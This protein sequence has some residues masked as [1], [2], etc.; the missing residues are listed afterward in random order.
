MPTI[1]GLPDGPALLTGLERL[2]ADQTPGG[3]TV[4]LSSASLATLGQLYSALNLTV[5][6]ERFDAAATFF[7]TQR[8]GD[9]AS[10]WFPPTV[11][12]ESGYG[13]T[14]QTTGGAQIFTRGVLPMGLDRIYE[15]EAEVDVVSVGSGE[16][17]YVRVG[18]A[19]LKSDFTATDG[20][21][22]AAGAVVGPIAAG[23]STTVR[24][25]FGRTALAGGFT[26]ADP[27]IAML[28]RP[29]VEV[30]LNAGAS[31]YYPGTVTRIRRLTVRDVTALVQAKLAAATLMAGNG[32]DY[33]YPTAKAL[34]DSS[35]P[36]AIT[37]AAPLTIDLTTGINFDVSAATSSFVLANPSGL[38]SNVGKGGRIRLP[39]DA[40]GGRAITSVGTAWKAAGGLAAN[41]LSTG[42]NVVDAI[43]YY[44]R[45]ATEVEWNVAR[46]FK[47]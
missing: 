16:T 42:A 35:A 27:S 45:S 28:F 43:Y 32:D 15:V 18:L 37:F 1:S 17:P 46:D 12:V 14:A 33:H 40:T 24:A 26:V 47:A 3:T 39:Q 13:Y 7:T 19:S 9:P 29:Y 38:S 4:D 31:A 10:T 2:P 23:G 11:V 25:R 34:Y 20:T 44:V 22:D 5:F 8:A 36:V 6:P 41:A 30:A 21:P